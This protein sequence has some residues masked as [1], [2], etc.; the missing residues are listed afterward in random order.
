MA[1]VT[2]ALV[3]KAALVEFKISGKV[4]L[5]GTPGTCIPALRRHSLINA[6]RILAEEGGAG[7][8]IL[9]DK[10][11]YTDMDVCIFVLLFRTVD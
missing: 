1:G 9:L 10:G 4:S 5:L 6:I 2:V 7:K 11:A 3:L 8:A